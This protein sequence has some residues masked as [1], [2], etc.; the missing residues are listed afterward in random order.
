MEYLKLAHATFNFLVMLLFMRQGWLGFKIRQGRLAG[1]PLLTAIRRHRRSGPI[2]A[3]LAPC[4]FLAGMTVG[5]IDHGHIFHYPYHF[6]TGATLVLCTGATFLVSRRLKGPAAPWRT[7]HGVL[8]C[9]ILVL[10]PVQVFLGL[11]I[12]L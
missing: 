9:V 12:L 6:L 7:V 3:A 10:Y 8:G 11:G 1:A 2:A 5:F 4:G